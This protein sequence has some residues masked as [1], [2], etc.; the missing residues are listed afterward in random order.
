MAAEYDRT[1]A[2]LDV[3]IKLLLGGVDV[4]TTL[5]G[6]D[7]VTDRLLALVLEHRA[8]LTARELEALRLAY[9]WLEL[10]ERPPFYPPM[11]LYKMVARAAGVMPGAATPEGLA[12]EVLAL[13]TNA[14]DL[15]GVRVRFLER[16]T[17]GATRHAIAASRDTVIETAAR[18]RVPWARQL[19]PGSCAFCAILASRGGVYTS[20]SVK[21]Q[22][23]DNCNCTATIA[24]GEWEGKQEARQLQQLWNES[25]GAADFSRHWRE[26]NQQ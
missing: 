20:K 21:F 6:V 25:R 17:A 19:A 23:H 13:G 7:H 12:A 16:V 9:P 1:R 14:A 15:E 4:P 18:N 3:A 2:A 8:R 24:V 5:E 22:A 10:P 11:A 26:D